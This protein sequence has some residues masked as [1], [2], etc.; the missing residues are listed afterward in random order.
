[1]GGGLRIERMAED[2]Q[3]RRQWVQQV[4]TPVNHPEHLFALEPA[5][6]TSESVWNNQASVLR[7]GSKHTGEHSA[8][9][10]N[11]Q[12]VFIGGNIYDDQCFEALPSEYQCPHVGSD[13]AA[14]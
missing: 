14:P 3:D 7:P 8:D 4:C 2:L 9:I 13:V 10:N 5:V 1:M 6:D 11:E 12:A